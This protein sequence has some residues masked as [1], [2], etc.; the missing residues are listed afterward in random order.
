MSQMSIIGL[1]CMF[2]GH[3]MSSKDSSYLQQRNPMLA[4]TID[5]SCRQTS[6][7]ATAKVDSDWLCSLTPST[8]C[9]THPGLVALES[10]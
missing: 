2:S 8:S 4:T 6:S 1:E 5:L 7:L 10:A 9:S 3:G